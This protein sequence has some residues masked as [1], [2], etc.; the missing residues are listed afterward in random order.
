MFENVYA[1]EN[2]MSKQKNS[3]IV[4]DIATTF[5]E[6]EIVSSEALNKYALSGFVKGSYLSGVSSLTSPKY[7]IYYD[8][9]GTIMR[10]CAYFNIKYDKAFPAFYATLSPTFNNEKTYTTSGFSAGSYGAEFLVFNS[11]DKT[12]V[13]DETSGTFLRIVGLSFTQNTTHALT[14]DD[15]YK[16]RANY[17]D[18]LVVNNIITNPERQE[19]IYDTILG[20]RS[21]Y[22]KREF[23]L[24]SPYIQDQD[25]ANSLMG[26]ITSKTMKP[27]KNIQVEV[28]GM[29]H[30]Q[31]GDIVTIDYEMPNGDKFLDE[32]KQFVVTEMQYARN[33][34]GPSQVI[35]VVQA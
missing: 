14:V 29:P 26:W 16:E 10:E 6:N 7:K 3:P 5:V 32:T 2:L 30:L 12:I 21:K 22:G 18:P 27:R 13:L 17:A 31:L 34:N 20:S 24:D 4:N 35:R 9:F 11:T 23:T 19:K 33:E 25:L 8:E 28:F 1:L 15:Y